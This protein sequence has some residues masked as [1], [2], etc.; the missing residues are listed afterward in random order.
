M[1]DFPGIDLAL[2]SI[3]CSLRLDH[4]LCGQDERIP[5]REGTRSAQVDHSSNTNITRR[6]RKET[7]GDSSD[8]SAGL[9]SMKGWNYYKSN[10]RYHSIDDVGE[11]RAFNHYRCGVESFDSEPQ[12]PSV[13]S[14]LSD[15]LSDEVFPDANGEKQA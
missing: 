1:D 3:V 8:E 2:D 13:G 12:Q 5:R 9:L 10:V 7:D 6:R 11:E 4:V 14:D 15:D